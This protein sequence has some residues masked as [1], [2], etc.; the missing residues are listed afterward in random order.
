MAKWKFNS[1]V[2]K[3][4]CGF[5]TVCLLMFCSQVWSQ[6]YKWTDENGQVH[7][8]D[9]APVDK[10]SV[11]I[12]SRLDKV[13]ISTDLTSPELMLKQQEEK[14]AIR[15]EKRQKLKEL[16]DKLPSISEACAEAK[17]HLSVI[18][19]RVYFTDEQGKEVK[20]SE[21]ERKERVINVKKMI[22]EKC[23]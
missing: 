15:K 17:R 9:R 21:K 7:F 1:G 18:E 23:R 8:G 14:D 22:S 10:T 13:N 11:D 12:S 3:H 16:K 19:G 20:V 6:V 2:S 5:I 4:I